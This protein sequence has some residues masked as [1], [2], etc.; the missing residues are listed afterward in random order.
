MT[1]HIL[2]WFLYKHCLLHVD[3]G[4]VNLLG[5]FVENSRK[6]YALLIE[7]RLLLIYY[8]EKE[9]KENFIF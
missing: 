2:R 1:I 6:Y 8:G 4:L 7:K 5:F 3:A 9:V